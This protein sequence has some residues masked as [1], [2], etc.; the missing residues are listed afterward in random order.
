M[1]ERKL[2]LLYE[3]RY[4]DIGEGVDS[5]LVAV[6]IAENEKS[7]RTKFRL[8]GFDTDYHG[9]EIISVENFVDDS[10][11]IMPDYMVDYYFMSKK[12]NK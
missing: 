11:Y 8:M 3:N 5:I 9:I 1:E 2:F 10:M 6:T 4:R 12:E 7:A